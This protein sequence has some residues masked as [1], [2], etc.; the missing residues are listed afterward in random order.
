M[1]GWAITANPN[2]VRH[3]CILTFVFLMACSSDS[4]SNKPKKI[5]TNTEEETKKIEKS[6]DISPTILPGIFDISRLRETTPI[7][8][9]EVASYQSVE[10]GAMMYVDKFMACE[11]LA[12]N[13]KNEEKY[14][15]AI[16]YA[17]NLEANGWTV[18]DSPNSK[19][20]V[21]STASSCA[22]KL[23][24]QVD[25]EKQL[26]RFPAATFDQHEKT[27]FRAILFKTS[28]A[29]FRCTQNLDERYYTK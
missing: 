10:Q 18:A 3:S 5:I 29:P 13:I 22:N 24:I 19:T 11:L 14:A 26:K 9:C 12:P 25:A 27:L 4:Q 1:Q 16:K 2:Y 17:L 28:T 21:L 23:T 20:L 6:F 7:G 8:G 15:V